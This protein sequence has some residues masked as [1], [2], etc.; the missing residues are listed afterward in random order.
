MR[1]GQT[2]R[3][4]CQFAFQRPEQQHPGCPRM[5]GGL[6]GGRGAG[7]GRARAPQPGVWLRPSLCAAAAA[8]LLL[9]R[10]C[11]ASDPPLVEAFCVSLPQHTE[12]RLAVSANFGGV[13][14]V[15][16]VAGVRGKD[17][18]PLMATPVEAIPDNY[19][20]SPRKSPEFLGA[21]GCTVSHLVAISLAHGRGL[22]YAL[23]LEDDVVP[24]LLPF[25]PEDLPRF[26][27]GLPRDWSIVQLA[28]IG[29]EA[30]WNRAYEGWDKAVAGKVAASTEFWSTAA[31]LI[32][33]AGM[34]SIL[35]RFREPDGRFNL[36]SLWAINLDILVLKETVAP[37]SYYVST[38]PLFTFAESDQSDIH[39]MPH[40]KSFAHYESD[41][42][43]HVHQLSRALSLEW[44]A[45]AWRCNRL[46]RNGGDMQGC[47]S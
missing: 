19:E 31:Y 5:P 36:T 34:A 21:L 17:V 10:P 32:S 45:T 23:I 13:L 29:D 46:R 47:L 35:G 3:L 14:N 24:D 22:D 44:S 33:R 38:P 4:R 9:A 16:F 37:G 20:K 27:A 6:H 12:R 39:L 18:A 43:A 7:R 8:L 30:M 40:K 11:A 1:N 15:S 2:A 28:L 26:V 42:R 25:W 41:G